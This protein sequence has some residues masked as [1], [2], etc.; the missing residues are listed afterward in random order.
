MRRLWQSFFFA[1]RGIRDAFAR[2]NHFQIHLFIGVVVI[3]VAIFLPLDTLETLLV[4]NAVFLV[5][6]AEMFNTALEVLTDLASDGRKDTRARSA[7][8]IAAGAVLLAALFSVLVGA[9]IFIPR[10]LEMF[11]DI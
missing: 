10:L 6:I 5:V 4:I 1:G 7:K 9:S 11:K 2:G 3:S 8:D